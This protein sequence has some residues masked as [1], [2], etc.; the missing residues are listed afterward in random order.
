MEVG[1]IEVLKES[2]TTSLTKI[3]KQEIK[4]HLMESSL[5]QR[6]TKDEFDPKA[7]KLMAKAGYDFTAHTEFKNL[8]IHEQPE[9]S[10]TQRKL[11]WEEHEKD[12][13]VDSNHITIEEVDSIEEKEGDSQR[14]SAFNRI[15]P[16]VSCA[17]VFERLSMTETEREGHQSTSS[18]D[19]CL[20]FQRLTMTFRKDKSTCQTSTTTRPSVFERLGMA[21]KKN[22]QTPCALIFNRLGDGSPHVKTDSCIDTKKNESTSRTSVWHR[23]KHTDVENCHCKE[24]PYEAKGEGEIHSNVPSRMKRKTFVT[25]NT[26][27]EEPHPTFISACLSSEEEDKYMSFLTEYMD[28]F[29]W[30]Y[31]EMLG[32]DPKVA[33]HHL[34][35]K[36]GT[37][38]GIY[39]YKVMPFGFKNVGATYQRAMQQVF[40][41]IL[42]KYV[43]CYI[44]DLVV[45][46]K[47]RQDHLKDLKVVF[48]Y[49]QKYQMRIDPP[50]CAFDETSGKFLDFIIRDDWLTFEGSSPTW[51]MVPTFSKVNEK[52]ENFVWDEACQN[53]FDS[54]KKYLLN[55]LVLGAPVPGKPLILYIA[56]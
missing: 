7:Y 47:R 31:K 43:E 18:L 44:D 11:L 2:F 52:K 19:R 10:S 39:C 20:V 46:S 13:V 16:H 28:I 15:R 22:V 30:L 55:P 33:A 42:H 54:I 21:K 38:K 23:I 25:L 53:A 45:I 3:V 26:N 49:L 27:Q 51:L 6:R 12:R 56:I 37:P 35:M 5:P 41:D 8:K 9:R 4:V 29:A 48:D 36:L 34:A 1:D 17:L 40:D 50:K 24:L 32:F 14:T